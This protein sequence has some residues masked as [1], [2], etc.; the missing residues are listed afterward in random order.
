VYQ[1]SAAS[2]SYLILQVCQPQAVSASRYLCLFYLS[3]STNLRTQLVEAD[4]VGEGLA[5][6]LEGER[7]PHV[8]LQSTETELYD[9][10]TGG[11][12]VEVL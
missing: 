4:A 12:L 3:D 2:T 5:A 8:P 6:G 10:G 1:S 7:D 11:H 9:R